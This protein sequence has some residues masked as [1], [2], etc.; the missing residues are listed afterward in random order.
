MGPTRRQIG[1]ILE[2]SRP[3][4]GP[5]GPPIQS[6]RNINFGH[7]ETCP[8]LGAT[9][10]PLGA[11]LGGSWGQVGPSRAQEGLLFKVTEILISVTLKLALTWG[12]HGT[13]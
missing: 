8:N 5:R 11:K 4:S 1:G 12:R 6:D 13:H 3:K 10:D 9:W 7:F 2:P